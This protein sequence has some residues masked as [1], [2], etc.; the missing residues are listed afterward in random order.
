LVHSSTI[1]KNKLSLKDSGIVAILVML[2]IFP[3]VNFFLRYLFELVLIIIFAGRIKIHNVFTEKN[4]IVVS[5]FLLLMSLHII[6][7]PSFS[8]LEDIVRFF[9][10]ILFLGY[11][12]EKITYKVIDITLF[13]LVVLNC[14]MVLYFE[15]G[16]S[17]GISRYIHT[18][19]LASSYGRHSGLFSN[20]AV[21]GL[22]SLSVIVYNFVSLIYT[23]TRK[24][25][26]IISVLLSFYLLFES[27]SKTS[28]LVVFLCIFLVI[29]HKAII[30]KN[31]K[32]LAISISIYSIISIFFLDSILAYRELNTLLSIIGGNS[33][34]AGTVYARIIIWNEIFTQSLSNIYFL[35]FGIPKVILDTV[36]TTYDNDLLWFFGRFGVV[37][38]FLVLFLQLSFLL[39]AFSLRLFRVS[40]FISFWIF[41]SILLSSISLGVITT[42]QVITI[43][44]ILIS[45]SIN[46]RTNIYDK[47]IMNG[48]ING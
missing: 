39:K 35:L 38:V 5:V 14:F 22:F 45:P 3:A 26:R 23:G 4:I 13:I 46:K 10:F 36:T 25:L 32:I 48:R 33:Q 11:L 6:I 8:E 30:N 9:I 29:F 21:L 28:M 44:L 37:G 1:N 43:S 12:S 17:F 19:D 42:P 16:D 47:L 40:H 20:V 2:V 15:N 41:L 31:I 18:K 34:A 27:G 7:S 24:R